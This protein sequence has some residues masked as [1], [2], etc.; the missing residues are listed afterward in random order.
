MNPRAP[1]DLRE[2]RHVDTLPGDIRRWMSGPLVV[3]SSLSS[4]D[5]PDGVG[6]P[7]PQWLVS[8]SHGGKRA[9]D[10]QLRRA[11]RAFGMTGAEE[12]NHHPGVSRAFFLVCDPARRVTCECKVTEDVITEPDGFRWTNPKPETGE[13]CRGCEYAAIHGQPCP[14]HSKDIQR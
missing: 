9:S 2:W 1:S 4:M 12:D 11:L 7:I 3:C 5:P 14:I 6:A 8:V 13:Q 10:K